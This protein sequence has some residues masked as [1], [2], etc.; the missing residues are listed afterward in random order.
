MDGRSR[1]VDQ[2]YSDKRLV[3]VLTNLGVHIEYSFKASNSLPLK[4]PR[5]VNHFDHFITNI[6]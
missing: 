5:D 4:S 6:D 3:T 1:K 2:G